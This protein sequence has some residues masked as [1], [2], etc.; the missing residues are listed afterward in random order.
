MKIMHKLLNQKVAMGTA[1]FMKV[2]CYIIIFLFVIM[3]ALSFM[4]RLQYHLQ[5]GEKTYAHAIY[6]EEDH[7]FSMRS[8][9]VKSNDSLRIHAAADDGTIDIIT[10]VAITIMYAINIIPLM[11]AYW[12]LAK[13]FANVAKG[14][15]FTQKNAHYL[16]YFGAIQAVVAIAVPFVKLLVVQ[17]ANSLVADRISLAIGTNMLNEFVPSVAFI[18]AA[19]II[20]YG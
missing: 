14:E 5:V 4:G 10:Y 6:A 3:L 20:N 1:K 12:F 16:L 2:I 8:L 13:V 17:I 15:I 18:V 19:Y 7:D 9:T 11:L